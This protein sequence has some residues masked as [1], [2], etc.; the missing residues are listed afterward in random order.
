MKITKT[1]YEELRALIEKSPVFRRHSDYRA[2]DLSD[3][4]W[5]WDC[6][7]STEKTKRHELVK[8]IYVYA[9]DTHIDTALRRITGTK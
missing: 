1:H 9:N 4:R 6:L 5:R 8:R 2:L 3:M 7:W